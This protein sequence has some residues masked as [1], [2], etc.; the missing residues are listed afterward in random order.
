MIGLLLIIALAVFG[1]AVY[2]LVPYRITSPADLAENVGRRVKV[3]GEISN[4][5][6]LGPVLDLQG[7]PLGVDI[8]YPFNSSNGSETVVGVLRENID[9][10]WQAECEFAIDDAVLHHQFK[11]SEA[12]Y[13]AT[14]KPFFDSRSPIVAFCSLF[15]CAL[16]P[17]V[18]SLII[19]RFAGAPL[20]PLFRIGL[21]FGFV[22]YAALAFAL[23]TFWLE[24]HDARFR[25]LA[26]AIG[27]ITFTSTLLSAWFAVA[28]HQNRSGIA[29]EKSENQEAHRST[30]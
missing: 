19:A 11:I 3:S 27:T 28:L 17:M 26:T 14:L 2:R 21:T 30:P 5:S 12:L 29:T 15:A 23:S 6:K 22:T 10:V 25:L 4:N 20:R 13:N 24:H 7:T 8:A 9:D 16:F 1:L 18:P